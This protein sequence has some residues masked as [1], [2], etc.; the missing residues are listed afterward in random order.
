MTDSFISKH[1]NYAYEGEMDRL[2]FSNQLRALQEYVYDLMKETVDEQGMDLVNL[3]IDAKNEV[4]SNVA[5]EIGRVAQQ[6]LQI[7]ETILADYWNI[8]LKDMKG[9]YDQPE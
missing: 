9:Q 5:D 1:D 3:Q 7:D 6:V 4:L 8:K 2:T